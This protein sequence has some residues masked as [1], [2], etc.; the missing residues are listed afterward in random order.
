MSYN[1]VSSGKRLKSGQHLII[2]VQGAGYPRVRSAQQ[3]D[4]DDIQVSGDTFKY[5]AKKG[6]TMVSVAKRFDISV[7]EIRRLNKFKK[8]K[9]LKSGQVILISKKSGEKQHSGSSDKK[10]KKQQLMTAQK[11]TQCEMVTA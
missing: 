8:R 6:D 5:K 10:T 4:R 11:R 3:S 1:S 9:T 7:D 2:P